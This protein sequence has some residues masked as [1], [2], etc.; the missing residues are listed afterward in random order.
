MACDYPLTAW[1]A[2]DKGLGKPVVVFQRSKASN[3]DNPMTLPCGRCTGCRL[4]YSRQWAVRAMH[5]AS[6]YENNCFVTL[7]YEDDRLPKDGSVS[8]R[9]HQLFLKRLRKEFYR[10]GRSEDDPG[11]RFLGCGE[12]GDRF[13]RPHYHYC[14]FNHDFPDKYHWRTERGQRLYR[15]PSLEKVWPYGHAEVGSVTFE[16]AAYVARYAMKKITGD[17]AREHYL[18]P[19]PVTGHLHQVQ[20]EFMKMSLRPGL[21]YGWFQKFR[22]DIYPSGFI[23]VNGHK[24]TIPRFYDLK[25]K[26]EEL[27]KL[28][29]Q[30]RLAGAKRKEERSPERRKARATVR[31][32]RMSLIKR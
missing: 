31:Q 2:F 19:H 3:P 22:D 4:E 26:E 16:S 27:H 29:I 7:T 20:P 14:L 23:V 30:R 25:L 12:Y 11:I 24:A 5:E 21:G 8:I 15:S 6:L 28:K 32:S 1:K 17:M 13:L 9:E 10:P 18:Q